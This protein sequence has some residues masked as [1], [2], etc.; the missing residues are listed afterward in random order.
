MRVIAVVVADLAAGF[1][2][3]PARLSDELAGRTVLNHTV[4][5]AG[6]VRGVDH[7][8]VVHPAGQE[9]ASLLSERKGVWT[10]PVVA[11]GVGRVSRLASARVW[12]TS[13]WRGGLGGAC[14]YDELLPAGP[15]IAAMG[16]HDATSAVIVR[17]DWCVFDPALASRQLAVHV[18]AP[19]Q[20][21]LCFS[22]APPG[23]GSVVAHRVVLE[24]IV[25]GEGGSFGQMLGYSPR[26][27]RLDPIGREVC[28]PIEPMVRDA[29]ARFVYDLSGSR[30]VVRRVAA[31]LGE[32]MVEADARAVVRAAQL[33]SPS[34]GKGE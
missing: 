10:L 14:V 1:F 28:V 15:I 9:V 7:V 30:A 21:G 23:L 16:G 26:R 32:G 18:E 4:T 13:C 8:V 27:P 5:R 12:A 19:E 6:R 2:G 22:Q 24:E 20:L 31:V 11:E 33:P 34:E 3:T 25:R 29:G 17:G